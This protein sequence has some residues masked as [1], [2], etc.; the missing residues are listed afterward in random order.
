MGICAKPIQILPTK[1]LNRILI[2][3]PTHIRLIIPEGVVL[4]P[5]LT[6]RVLILQS[7]G[8][9]SSSRYVRLVFQTISMLTYSPI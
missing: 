3:K 1:Q 8:L 7:E 4:Q 5:C 2:H 9:V 6:V